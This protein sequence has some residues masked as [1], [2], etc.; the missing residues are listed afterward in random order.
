MI[1]WAIAAIPAFIILAAMV[2]LGTVVVKGAVEYSE[3]ANAVAARVK[4]RQYEK[5]PSENT[6]I[7]KSPTQS[8]GNFVGIP[9]R[10][11]GNSEQEKCIA[12]ERRLAAETPDE[13]AMRQQALEAERN[14]NMDRTH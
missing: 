13:K 8:T 2:A 7:R 14:A 3:R 9:D 5:E 10:C 6:I 12:E 11:K 4:S 1:K